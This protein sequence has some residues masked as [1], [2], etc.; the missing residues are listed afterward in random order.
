MELEVKCYEA[1]SWCSCILFNSFAVFFVLSAHQFVPI[2]TK[3]AR[4][5]NFRVEFQYSRQGENRDVETIIYTAA[6]C[7]PPRHDQRS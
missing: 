1:S 3:L 5:S 6:A 2:I 4:I 7:A